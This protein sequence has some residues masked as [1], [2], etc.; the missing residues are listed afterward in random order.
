MKTYLGPPQNGQDEGK[1]SEKNRRTG[2]GKISYHFLKIKLLIDSELEDS[3]S[4]I[5]IGKKRFGEF[6]DNND[7][8]CEGRYRFDDDFGEVCHINCP[9]DE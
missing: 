1:D 2:D 6:W 5:E 3:D 4:Q 9:H 8:G 7:C